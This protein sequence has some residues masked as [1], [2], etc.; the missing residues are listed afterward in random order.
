MWGKKA[1][2]IVASGFCGA[3]ISKFHV[4]STNIRDFLVIFAVYSAARKGGANDF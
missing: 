4:I 2:I 3:K 1:S